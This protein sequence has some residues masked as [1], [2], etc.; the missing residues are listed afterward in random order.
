MSPPL[1]P[2]SPPPFRAIRRA[3]EIAVDG[4]DSS[5]ITPDDS[6]L[7]QAWGEEADR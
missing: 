6:N 7:A 2:L 5:L 1:Q 4:V 3:P